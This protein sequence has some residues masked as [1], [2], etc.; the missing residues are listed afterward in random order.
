MVMLTSSIRVCGVVALVV[1]NPADDAVLFGQLDELVVM[2]EQLC[3]GF[4][5][6]DVQ[7]ALNGILGNRVVGTCVKGEK[8]GKA[9]HKMLLTVRSK[10]DHSC[11]GLERVDRGLV[12][13]IVVSFAQQKEVLKRTSF[14]VRLAFFGVASEPRD[15]R[16]S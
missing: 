2:R 11:A 6:Q 10:D 1:L 3:R 14:R 7:L 13:H 16:V 5:D 15:N 12:C 8:M 9:G 4:C